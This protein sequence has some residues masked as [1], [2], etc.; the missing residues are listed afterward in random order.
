MDK[1]KTNIKAAMQK[2]LE[3][4]LKDMSVPPS[5]NQQDGPADKQILIRCTEADRE[6]WKRAADESKM[7]LSE[8]IRTS[9]VEAAKNVLECDHPLNRRAFYPWAEICRACGRRLRG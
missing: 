3:T 9:L 8:F 7:T 4:T 5:T 1:K 2:E 6:Y